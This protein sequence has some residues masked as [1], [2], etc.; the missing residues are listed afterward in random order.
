MPLVRKI[1][2]LDLNVLGLLHLNKERVQ[3]LRDAM[4]AGK[5][6]EMVESSINDPGEDYS[7]ILVDGQRFA[8]FP[9]Y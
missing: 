2:E 4:A 1:E 8:Y 7:E 6:V 3:Q 5:K 9:G